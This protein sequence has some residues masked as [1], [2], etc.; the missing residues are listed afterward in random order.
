MFLMNAVR[1]F[2]GLSA[3]DRR[4]VVEAC[5]L[6]LVSAV[7]L[8]VLSFATVRRLL[9]S[10]TGIAPSTQLQE[11]RIVWGVRAVSTRVPFGTTCLIEA[12]AAEA[13]LRRHGHECKLCLGV[14]ARGTSSKSLSAHAWIERQGTVVLGEIDDLSEYAVLPRSL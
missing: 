12:L 7:G 5:A 1:R 10:F 9:D 13:M 8:R 4:T 3:D 2:R 6:L 11:H 14:S